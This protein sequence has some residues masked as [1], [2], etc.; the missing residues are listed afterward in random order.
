MLRGDLSGYW[1]LPISRYRIVYHFDH[2]TNWIVVVAVG[3][4][5]EGSPEDIYQ[6]LIRLIKKGKLES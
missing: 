2:L 3:I 5:K 4:R 6:S 1:S